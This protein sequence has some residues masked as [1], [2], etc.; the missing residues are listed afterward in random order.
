MYRGTR[1]G[2]PEI[3]TGPSFFISLEGFARTYGQT[4]AFYLDLQNPKEVDPNTWLDT[5]GMLEYMPMSDKIQFNEDLED[6]GYD[7]IIAYHGGP[8]D[9]IVVYL[10]DPSLAELI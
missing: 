10:L 6:E 8:A 2:D 5:V 4:A 1:Q 7:S 9:M 3:L